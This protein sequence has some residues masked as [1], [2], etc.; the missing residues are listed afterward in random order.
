[1]KGKIFKTFIPLIFCM[2]LFAFGATANAA[3]V[4]E[5]G[6]CGADGDNVTYV[7]YADGLL[8]IS[9]TGLWLIGDIMVFMIIAMYLGIPTVAVL[10][11]SIFPK[12]YPLLE[13]KPFT[14]AQA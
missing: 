6:N 10:K 1:M 13:T 8:E 14:I 9:G 4:V 7:L 5:I 2:V 12:E 11:P 3:E